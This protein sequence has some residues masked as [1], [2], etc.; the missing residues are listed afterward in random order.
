M[1]KIFA[2][3]VFTLTLILPGVASAHAGAHVYRVDLD[4]LNESGVDGHAV[5]IEKGDTLK[6]IIRAKGLVPNM[7]HPQHI[8]GF[9]DTMQDAV[10]PPM[11]AAGEDGLLTLVE[12]LPFYGPVVVPLTPF[13]MADNGT[14]EYVQTFEDV[15]IED[16]ENFV[17]VLHG[18]FVN[19]EYI[20]TLPVACGEIMPLSQGGR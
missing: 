1:K 13:P 8:H 9:V 10:C 16:L 18:K 11:S 12:G 19:G 15:A 2:M 7:L 14:I 6:V 17:I 3:L 20:P 4:P 5:V